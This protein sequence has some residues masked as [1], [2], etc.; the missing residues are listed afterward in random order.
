M[1]EPTIDPTK[2]NYHPTQSTYNG[3]PVYRSLEEMK[4]G[5]GWTENRVDVVTFEQLYTPVSYSLDRET[6][7]GSG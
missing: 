5:E 2:L 3:L 7:P 1:S 4:E 6:P